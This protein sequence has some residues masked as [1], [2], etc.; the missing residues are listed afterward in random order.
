[1]KEV[2]VFQYDEWG[3]ECPGCKTLIDLGDSTEVNRDNGSTIECFE[4][5]AKFILK[6]PD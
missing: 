2:D 1:M 3:V 4:C 5:K 6:S